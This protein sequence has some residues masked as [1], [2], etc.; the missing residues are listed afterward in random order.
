MRVGGCWWISFVAED[1]IGVLADKLV[2]DNM[3]EVLGKPDDKEK[4]DDDTLAA[5]REE[6]LVV[7]RW[8]VTED[9]T[10]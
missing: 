6:E 2:A 4:A 7:G 10:I 3:M 5:D 9:V 1:K 8:P